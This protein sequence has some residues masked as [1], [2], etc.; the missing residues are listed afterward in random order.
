MGPCM[1][2]VGVELRSVDLSRVARSYLARRTARAHES[3]SSR[4]YLSSVMPNWL[5]HVWVRPPWRTLSSPNSTPFTIIVGDATTADRRI[6]RRLS[7]GS[8]ARLPP[9]LPPDGPSRSFHV[10][11]RQRVCHARSRKPKEDEAQEASGSLQCRSAPG[12]IDRVVSICSPLCC[13][14]MRE[15]SKSG[16]RPPLSIEAPANQKGAEKNTNDSG[17]PPH[18]ACDVQTHVKP[19]TKAR[20]HTPSG[21]CKGRKLLSDY[22]LAELWPLCV[23]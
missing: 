4:T 22:T 5:P 3:I 8:T 9:M 20:E 11:K 12:R 18:S 15:F 16:I 21:G 10:T 13:S 19:V 6:G 17:A 23:V 7:A 1:G 2:R 14:E